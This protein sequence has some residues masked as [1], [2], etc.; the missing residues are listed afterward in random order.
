MK[1]FMLVFIAVEIL[2][3]SLGLAYCSSSEKEKNEI[4][5]FV[6]DF[7]GEYPVNTPSDMR[8]LYLRKDIFDSTEFA[9][10]VRSIKNEVRS[11]KESVA[12]FGSVKFVLK[13]SSYFE[14][15]YSDSNSSALYPKP[16]VSM[17]IKDVQD[18]F[19]ESIQRTIFA[20]WLEKDSI[21]F[22]G[23]EANVIAKSVYRLN[24]FYFDTVVVSYQKDELDR[25]VNYKINDLCRIKDK[26][27]FELQYFGNG[28]SYFSINTTGKPYGIE[29]AK[30]VDQWKNDYIPILELC[31][32][33]SLKKIDS[34]HYEISGIIETTKA[35]GDALFDYVFQP[36]LQF[37]AE[38]QD[39][40]KIFEKKERSENNDK[41]LSGRVKKKLYTIEIKDYDRLGDCDLTEKKC[42]HLG[43]AKCESIYYKVRALPSSCL[44]F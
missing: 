12:F 42:F 11:Q 23:D 43:R 32:D 36:K 27:T 35:R 9:E 3:C 5:Q 25:Y 1:L 2:F 28:L 15:T 31:D 37:F 16:I 22:V 33:C 26:L 17:R 10:C 30:I 4:E 18:F 39:P 6:Y 44:H 14:L 41:N 13:N 21:V 34:V 20:N 7:F 40:P 29:K 8:S 19:S 24:E 38:Y